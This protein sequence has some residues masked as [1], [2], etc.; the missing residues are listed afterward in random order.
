M[1]KVN[2]EEEKENNEQKPAE[3]IEIV[4]DKIKADENNPEGEQGTTSPVTTP[5]SGETHFDVFKA[6]TD[7]D[8]NNRKCLDCGNE[9]P[10]HV[11]IN[12]G[13]VLCA[14]C[15]QIHR[16][17]GYQISYVREITDPWDD[18]LM[19]YML[20]GSNT[21]FMRSMDILGVDKTLTIEQKYK[22]CG[23]DYYRRNL[24]CKVFNDELLEIDYEN[25]NLQITEVKEP[26]EEFATYQPGEFE[27]ENPKGPAKK[28]KGRFGFIGVIGGKILKT[29]KAVGKKVGETTV[30]KFPSATS[31]SGTW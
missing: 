31:C 29:G 5:P 17:L 26:F 3:D 19:S 30:G 20:M 13:I 28:K 6:L 11:S 21:K 2:Q 22:T 24:K 7:I 10:T 18:H 16:G 8:D 9:D 27:L 1:E 12:N 25:P 14:Q 23:V 15:A 4:E